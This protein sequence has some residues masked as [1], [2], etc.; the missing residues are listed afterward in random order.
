M[1]FPVLLFFTDFFS[2]KPV[3][4][5]VVAS[6]SAFKWYCMAKNSESGVLKRFFCEIILFFLLCL[7]QDFYTCLD[8]GSSLCLEYLSLDLSIPELLGLLEKSSLAISQH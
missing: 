1:G 4:S 6:S 8:F 2:F 7:L 3:C 5:P